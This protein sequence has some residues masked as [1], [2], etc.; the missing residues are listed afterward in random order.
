MT[1]SIL[2]LSDVLLDILRS[3]YDVPDTTGPD[4][5]FE[6][7]EFDSLVLVEIAVDLSR[8]F[9]IDVA[10]SELQEAGNIAATVALLKSKGVQG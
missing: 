8:R 3:D 1:T 10:D 2:P 9:D 7:L 4:T 6:S 5:D